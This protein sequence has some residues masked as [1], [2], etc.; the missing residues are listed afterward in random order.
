[1]KRIG[2]FTSGGDAPGMNACIR[3]VVRGACYH[4]I[5]VYGIRRGY[6]G[7]IAGDLYKMESHSVSNIVQRGGTILK[8]ARSK[9][10]MTPEG[11]KT[12]YDNLQAA[13]IEGLVAIGGNGTFTGAMIFGNEYG[14]PTVGAPGTIDND[15]YGTDYT[16]GFDT[17]VNTAL[18]AID[19]IRD[20]ASSHD[21]IF[22]IEVMGRD[23]GYIAVQSGIA[24]GAELV[25]VPE[26]LTPISEVVETLKQGWSRSKSS[27]IIIVAEG[28]DEGS[29]QE[30]AEKIK[31]QVDENADIRVTTLGHTQRGGPPSAYDRIL[32]SRLG[33]GALEGLIGGQKNVMAGIINNDLVYTPF[34]DTIRLPKP[35]NEDLLRMVKILSV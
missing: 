13:G 35:I 22:F 30:V 24:G 16:I 19:R 21:R 26:V 10:F 11:R 2:V 29:A 23:S 4:G 27:S 1:M 6:S 25:M 28:D 34:E 5:E 3:A 7:M 8:S 31:G 12:A 33:L 17:A 32:A 18:D 20:T 15:L 14:I 9:E